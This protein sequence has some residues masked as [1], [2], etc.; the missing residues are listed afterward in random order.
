LLKSTGIAKNQ[1]NREQ[2]RKSLQAI[3]IALLVTGKAV[4]KVEDDEVIRYKI[5]SKPEIHLEYLSK[6]KEYL[7]SRLEYVNKKIEE[8][9]KEQEG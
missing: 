9:K 3:L 7:E 4:S 2:Y 6:E 5:T 8:F 1:K